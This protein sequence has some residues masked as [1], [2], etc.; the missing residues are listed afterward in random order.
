MRT[1]TLE[2][3]QIVDTDIKQAWDFFSSPDNLS[4]ITP[5]YLNFKVLSPK[6]R[7]KVYSGMRISYKVHPILGIPMKWV[8]RIE[9]VDAPYSFVDTQEKGP[10]KLWKHTHTFTE[11]SEGVL[12]KDRVEYSLP[13]GFLGAIAHNL[14]VKR[15]LAG[16]FE[17]RK[18]VISDI[19]K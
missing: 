14:F 16:I 4:L 7:E 5:S 2:R 6:S 15:Q 19:F 10:Y 13:F 17:F 1:F 18:K 8:T 3:E 12:I 9:D 11:T